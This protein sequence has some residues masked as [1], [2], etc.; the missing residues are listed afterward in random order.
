MT[1]CLAGLRNLKNASNQHWAVKSEDLEE[2]LASVRNQMDEAAST[3][4][5][6]MLGD[7]HKTTDNLKDSYTDNR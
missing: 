4:Q 5:E 1:N 7:V 6:Y 2:K 3:I